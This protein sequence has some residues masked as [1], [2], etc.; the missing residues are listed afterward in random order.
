MHQ[1]LCR[2]FDAGTGA[3]GI[4]KKSSEDSPPCMLMPA[5]WRWAKPCNMA[6]SLAAFSM[7]I[8]RLRAGCRGP[9]QA[10]STSDRCSKFQI[11]V[12]Y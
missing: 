6:S 5:C 9:L 1:A 12:L 4:M 8:V 2:S 7:A 3:Q 11:G 10:S